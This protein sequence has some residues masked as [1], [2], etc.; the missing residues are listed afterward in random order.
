MKEIDF[1]TQRS[2][3]KSLKQLKIED[4]LDYRIFIDAAIRQLKIEYPSMTWREIAHLTKVDVALLHKI[5]KGERHLSIKAFPLIV[6]FLKDLNFTGF[7]KSSDIELFTLMWKL[8][9]S[10]NE[11][12][13]KLLQ[14][15]VWALKSNEVYQVANHEASFF[16]SWLNPTIYSLFQTRMFRGS[17]KEVALQVINN[18]KI[19]ASTKEVETS[20]VE[21]LKL[22]ILQ[23]EGNVWLV[24]SKNISTGKNW[25]DSG[26][27]AYQKECLNLAEIALSSFE[28]EDRRIQTLTLHLDKSAASQ[29]DLE[30]QE[31]LEKV[32][33][34]AEKSGSSKKVVQLNT[35]YFPLSLESAHD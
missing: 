12:E 32:K 29:I 27:R 5:C 24:E 10:K 7:K 34:I 11:E 3:I 28:K 22:N 35:Q 26:V 30:L 21:L 4:Y 2:E 8:G 23:Q 13:K 20:L 16:N 19:E 33:L 1:N 17:L 6:E 9:R 14:K 25:G 15:Q 18:L 31:F